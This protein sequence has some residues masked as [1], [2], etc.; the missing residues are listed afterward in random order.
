MLLT[1]LEIPNIAFVYLVQL[2]NYSKKGSL[3]RLIVEH[4][5]EYQTLILSSDNS[6]ITDD[7]EQS[8]SKSSIVY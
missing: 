2:K 1:L 3:Q 6:M 4:D 5:Y 7:D 8:R